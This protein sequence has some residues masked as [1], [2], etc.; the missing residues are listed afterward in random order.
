MRRRWSEN[1]YLLF[2]V[3]LAGVWPRWLRR[4]AIVTF[5]VSLF[6]WYAVTLMVIVL[7][8]V[9]MLSDMLWDLW[10]DE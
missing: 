2:D 10:F 3:I 5:P 7:H 4:L 1:T 8:L 6:L 9:A